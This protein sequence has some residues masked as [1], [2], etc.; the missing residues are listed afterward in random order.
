MR[1][2]NV[3]ESEERNVASSPAEGAP[4]A[5]ARAT[6]PTSLRPMIGVLIALALTLGLGTSGARAALP[7]GRAYELVSPA[8]KNGGDVLIESTRTRAATSGDALAFASLTAFGD[9]N[10]T[11]I[12][13][14]YLAERRTSGWATHGITPQQEPMSSF[15]LFGG[16][17]DAIYE[18][19]LS[20]DLSHGVVR[21]N[22]F[23]VNAPNVATV[24]NLFMRSDLLAPGLGTHALVTDSVAPLAA[25]QPGT[26]AG[27]Y[28]PF[29]AGASSDF[30]HVIFESSQNLTQQAIDAG[31]PT[32]TLQD[33]KLYEWD[34]GLVR[35]VGIL[36]ASEGGGIVP[37]AVAGRGASGVN[38]FY[39]SDAIS[40]DGSR[41]FFTDPVPGSA[42]GQLYMRENGTDTVHINASETS[43]P[44][45][46]AAT[47]WGATPDGAHVFFTSTD[48][49]TNA[50]PYGGLYRY[51]V[52]APA[53]ERL[54]LLSVDEEPADG[55]SVN[56]VAMFGASDDGDRVYFVARDGRLV[57]DAPIP[58]NPSVP[59]IYVWHDGSLS[60]VGKLFNLA[61]EYQTNAGSIG[62]LLFPKTA[63][64][65]PDGKHLL[66]LSSEGDQVKAYNHGDCSETN[67]AGPCREVYIYSADTNGGLG[68]LSCA[69]CDPG[70]GPGTADA[71]VNFSAN[72]SAARSSSHVNNPLSDDGRWAFFG[73]KQALTIEDHNTD[74]DV[75]RYETTTGDLDL[76][77]SGGVDSGDSYFLDASASGR[78]VFFATRDR[79]VGWDTDAS[80]DIYDARVGGGFPEPPSIA[81]PCV[82]EACQGQLS[83]PPALRQPGSASF[84]GSGR[85]TTKPSTHKKKKCK[86]GTARKRVK[87]KVRCVKKKPRHVRVGHNDRRGR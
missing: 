33:E 50:V 38:P 79:L 81:P 46:G 67:D 53:G 83:A 31:L 78:D 52:D 45:S 24:Q 76:L 18:G 37:R 7:D 15:L 39:T 26:A 84:Q 63:R 70:G 13:V 72:T 20:D 30:G 25:L 3:I 19:E 40:D 64:V 74:L 41:I 77:S 75:Y 10:G 85:A 58:S 29:L 2:V 11:G 12:S 16:P 60:Y 65:S 36:P 49:L 21:A 5:P 80:Y 43:T 86:R 56:V 23:P 42:E 14:D 1:T 71:A 87:G 48:Q 82:G 66:F 28:K 44:A 55:T 69:S 35:L 62:W 17:G 51:D 47:F 57:A 68:Q 59:L 27:Q 8:D 54:T 4:Y 22:A 34:H 32:A 9:V 61:F 73:T 6:R